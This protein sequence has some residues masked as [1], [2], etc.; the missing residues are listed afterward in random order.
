[1][2]WFYAKDGQQVG[3]VSD[4][5]F[6]HLR[7]EG[8]IQPT[9]LVW[10]E[11]MGEWQPH[12]N[13]TGTGPFVCVLCKQSFPH[14]AVLRFSDV[15]VCAQCK[16]LYL[17]QLREGFHVALPTTLPFAGFWIRG[18]A[19][20]IDAALFYS[21]STAITMASG[22]TFLQALGFSQTDWTTRDSVLLAVDMILG[23][24]YDMVLV[25]KYGGTVGKLIC[26]LRVVTAEGQRLSYRRALGRSLAGWVSLLPCGLGFVFAAFDKE[27]HALHDL[28]CNTRV[29]WKK[30]S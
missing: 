14:D 15:V 9:T 8:T 1:M 16:P 26:R 11:G 27:K 2:Q 4:T 7:H 13:V 6:E 21:V 28:I 20:F 19:A 25:A 23:T 17:Q 5:E 18:L 12:G 24:I 3:P 10:R 30:T 29:I 22:A